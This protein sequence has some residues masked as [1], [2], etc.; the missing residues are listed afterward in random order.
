[1]AAGSRSNVLTCATSMV[2]RQSKCSINIEGA[3]LISAM[4]QTSW[5][6]LGIAYKRGI[7]SALL[8]QTLPSSQPTCALPAS[9]STSLSFTQT[10]EHQLS[11]GGTGEHLANVWDLGSGTP[12]RHMCTVHHGVRSPQELIPLLLCVRLFLR[13]PLC[14]LPLSLAP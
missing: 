13:F 3:D 14:P 9:H 2:Q 11:H 1:M 10:F 5:Q 12:A 8:A 6:V 7:V 4:C